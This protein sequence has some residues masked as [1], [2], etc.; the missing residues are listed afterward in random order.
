MGVSFIELA[1]LPAD[2]KLLIQLICDMA[3]AFD[4]LKSIALDKS[5]QFAF[6]RAMFSGLF[7][8]ARKVRIC[9]SVH[10]HAVER[11]FRFT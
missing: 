3:S 10:C 6:W 9:D 1:H 5:C 8:V 4:A 7:R 11:R 2:K